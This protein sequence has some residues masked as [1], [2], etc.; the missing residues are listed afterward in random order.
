M[1]SL[2]RLSMFTRNYCFKSIYSL[3]QLYPKGNPRLVTPEFVPEDL[4]VKFTG[5]IP[6]NQLKITY[7]H[8][9]GPGGQNVNTSN[10]KVDLRFNVKSATWISDEIKEKLSIQERHRINKEG[11]LVVKSEVTRHQHLNLADALEKL[12]AMIRKTVA[13]DDVTVSPENEELKRKRQIKAARQRIFEK[14]MRS[15]IKQHRRVSNADIE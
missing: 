7:S 1:I 2:S 12:R 3:E 13:S 9:S 6:M 15:E 10:S 4:N 11:F 14:R 5:F 8:S